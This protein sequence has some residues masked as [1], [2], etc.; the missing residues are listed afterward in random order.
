MTVMSP[1]SESVSN[2]YRPDPSDLSVP[3]KRAT[4][5]ICVG[6][7]MIR[8]KLLNIVCTLTVWSG[9]KEQLLTPS[10]WLLPPNLYLKIRLLAIPYHFLPLKIL[11]TSFGYIPATWGDIMLGFARGHSHKNANDAQSR[12]S[13]KMATRRAGWPECPLTYKFELGGVNNSRFCFFL[14][15]VT[16]LRSLPVPWLLEPLKTLPFIILLS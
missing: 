11:L 1:Q 15:S 9:K 4:D 12:H 7:T 14:L 13:Y 2:L 8:T 3:V 6:K 16:N 10:R 5:I